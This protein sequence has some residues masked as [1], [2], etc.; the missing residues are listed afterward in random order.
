MS[1]EISQGIGQPF[2]SVMNQ[3]KAPR[4]A[5]QPGVQYTQAFGAHQILNHAAGQTAEP[6]SCG[7]GIFDGFRAAEGHDR[8][9][10]RKVV[11]QRLLDGDARPG[12]WLAQ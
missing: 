2:T 9:Q 5:R 1:D 12:A 11:Q 10:G 7:R 6:Q 4:Q 8:C 3:R